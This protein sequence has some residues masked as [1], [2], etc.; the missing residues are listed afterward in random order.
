V[1]IQDHL[2]GTISSGELGPGDRLPSENTL[3]RKFQTTRS[4]VRQALARLDFEG[5]IHRQAGLGTFVAA[6]KVE[7]RLDTRLRQSFEEQMG[8]AGIKVD[9]K[10]LSFELMAAPESVRENM[11]LRGEQ[12]VYRLQ[13]LRLINGEL[14]GLE[15]RFILA[16]YGAE[17]PADSLT[18]LS[19]IAIMDATTAGPVD[20]IIVSVRAAAAAADIASKLELECG[21]PVLFRDHRFF[22]RAGRVILCGAAIYRGDAYRFSYTLRYDGVT[23]SNSP[24][25]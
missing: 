20:S 12:S 7:A 10:L 25:P 1:R 15:D 24:I 14:V 16:E 19:A 17:I 3:A 21:A 11:G 9:F 23:P 4:T 13:R 5:L 6:P 22:D 8:D 2:R 18:T